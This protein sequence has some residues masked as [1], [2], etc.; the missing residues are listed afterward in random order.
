MIH[1]PRVVI[2]MKRHTARTNPLSAC[3]LPMSEFN[4]LSLAEVA[5]FERRER[6]GSSADFGERGYNPRYYR[7]LARRV[8][9]DRNHL[10]QPD[11]AA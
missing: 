11:D 4:H 1:D 3:P 10:P 7:L 5:E 6:E 9:P 2:V 8:C